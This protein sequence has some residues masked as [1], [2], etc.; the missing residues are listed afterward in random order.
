[1]IDIIIPTYNRPKDIEKFVAEIQKQAYTDYHVYIIDDCGE[2]P[3]EHL[4]PLNGRFT[5]I[6]LPTNKG[7]A[8]ARN[9]GIEQGKGDII[10]SLDDDAWFENED[11]LFIVQEYFN[12]YPTLGCLMFDVRSPNEAYLSQLQNIQADGQIIGSHITCGC[13]YSRKAIEHV[14]GF[15]KFIHSVGEETDITLKMVHSGYELRFAKRIHVYHNYMPGERSAAWYRRLRFNATRNDM[16]IVAM[17]YPLIW[18]LPYF[19]GKYLSHVLFSFRSN[20]APLSVGLYSLLALPVALLKLPLA[21]SE[22]KPLTN[23]QFSE[24]LKIRW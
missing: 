3:I 11:S 8:Y 1:M 18:V 2:H 9:V 15:N 5:Y 17:H 23:K 13:A 21:L 12:Q 20:R 22:R 16:L 14:G 19:F 24:W 10:V 7:Q 6:K 4:I